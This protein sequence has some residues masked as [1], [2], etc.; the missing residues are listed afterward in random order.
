MSGLHR[1]I[2]A[3]QRTNRTI[4][5]RIHRNEMELKKLESRFE[6]MT[7]LIAEM[8]EI[9]SKYMELLYAVA[10]K[11]PGESRHQ[12]A[13]RYIRERETVTADTPQS[14]GTTDK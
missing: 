4:L 13:L 1:D 6:S 2:E 3:N 10:S 5:T 9:E 12:T 8:A 7:R 11:F 14:T